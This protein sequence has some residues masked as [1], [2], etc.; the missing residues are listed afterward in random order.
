METRTIEREAFFYP[1]GATGD[2][3]IKKKKVSML[4]R[5]HAVKFTLNV[6]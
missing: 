4:R 3:F 5:F 1:E 6:W 2:D